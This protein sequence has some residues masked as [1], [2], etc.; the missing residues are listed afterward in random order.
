[1]FSDSAVRADG[2]CSLDSSILTIIS[3]APAP[4]ATIMHSSPISCFHFSAPLLDNH[5][6]Q[7]MTLNVALVVHSS[8]DTTTKPPNSLLS[9]I[10]LLVN[11]STVES[12]FSIERARPKDKEHSRTE[13]DEGEDDD[14]CVDGLHVD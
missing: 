10:P 5:V 14:Y 11:T 13:R 2:K 8:V 3:S 6:Y 1:M 9:P 12:E 7:P 4:Y